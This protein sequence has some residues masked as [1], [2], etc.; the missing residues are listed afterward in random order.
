MFRAT[1]KLNEIR[2]QTGRVYQLYPGRPRVAI[3]WVPDAAIC[4]HPTLVRG[5]AVYHPTEGKVVYF[6]GERRR[7]GGVRI[8]VRT[9]ARPDLLELYEL[10]MKLSKELSAV[11]GELSVVSGRR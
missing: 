5:T 3:D 6:P 9:K 8:A 10:A 1:G 7:R 4:G 2:R 11:S